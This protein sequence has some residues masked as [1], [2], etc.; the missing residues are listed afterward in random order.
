MEDFRIPYTALLLLLFAAI[1]T[2]LVAFTYEQTKE[3]IEQNER[4]AVL[5]S[6]RTLVPPEAHDNDLLVD[7]ITVRD[8]AL[9]GTDGPV[10][11]YRARLNHQPM[12]VVLTPVAPDGYNGTI[13][14]LVGIYYHDNALSGVRVVSHRE[15]PGLGDDIDQDR[16]DWILGFNGRSLSNPAPEAWKVRRDGGVFDQFT[17]ATISPRAVVKAVHNS[18]SYFS[19]HRDQLFAPAATGIIGK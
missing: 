6:L 15:T 13:K 12:A 10:T 9:L 19:A 4:A 2:G 14:L 1:G 5:R 16:S 11:V 7:T 8:R 3:R 17:G 18:L